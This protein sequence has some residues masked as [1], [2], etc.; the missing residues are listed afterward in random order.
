VVHPRRVAA[1]QRHEVLAALEKAAARALAY[2][3]HAE[4]S[5]VEVA[6]AGNVADPERDVIEPHCAEGIRLPRGRTSGSAGRRA[7]EHRDAGDEL[8]TRELTAFEA[9]H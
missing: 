9:L 7:R 4:V 6:G 2:D 1:E 5:D 8:P 3:L